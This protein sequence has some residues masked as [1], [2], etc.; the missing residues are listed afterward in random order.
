[1]SKFT[2]YKVQS[3]ALQDSKN[4]LH[5]W[6][7][8]GSGPGGHTIEDAQERVRKDM[9]RIPVEKLHLVKFAIVKSVTEEELVE[10]VEGKHA[11][12]YLLK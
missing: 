7:E 10:V 5:S 6:R 12:F 3:Y 1:M 11:S 8:M 4:G 9:A 2:F